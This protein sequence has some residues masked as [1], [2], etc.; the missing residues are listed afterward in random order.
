[1][2]HVDLFRRLYYNKK[3]VN[4][5]SSFSLVIRIAVKYLHRLFQLGIRQNRTELFNCRHVFV[6][7]TY[8]PNSYH[9]Y[10]FKKTF[11]LQVTNANLHIEDLL[12]MG[13][14]THDKLRDCKTHCIAFLLLDILLGDL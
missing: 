13:C 6:Y 3:T 14:P 7:S 9:S 8:Q 12:C 5:V 4:C 1:M 2:Y 11:C 10:F